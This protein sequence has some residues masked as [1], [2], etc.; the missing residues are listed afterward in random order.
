MICAAAGGQLEHLRKT[1]GFGDG[2]FGL[3]PENCSCDAADG[4]NAVGTSSL[5]SM[6]SSE[7][8]QNPLHFSSSFGFV[9]LV[10]CLGVVAA[11]SCTRS[12][13]S[14]TRLQRSSI[15]ETPPLV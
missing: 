8:W 2:N 5:F 9:L 1:H 13:G 4:C 6:F 10:A 14:R 11:S 7:A 3:E 12:T 15:P